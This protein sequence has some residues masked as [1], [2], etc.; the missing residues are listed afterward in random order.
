MRE[1][2][3]IL[4]MLFTLSAMVLASGC[5]RQAVVESILE[6][7]LEK[8]TGNSA[9]VDLEKGGMKLE[10]ADGV[11]LET[12]ESVKLP[13]DFPQ[14][15]Y[16]IDGKIVAV[17]KN[18]YGA[19]YNLSVQ[20]DKSVEEAK[21]IYEEKLKADGWTMGFSAVAGEVVMF[22]GQKDKRAVSISLMPDKETR[23]TSVVITLSEQTE[24]GE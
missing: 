7:Q 6:N 18:V 23:K 2:R 12:G 17:L 1:Y 3:T 24:G 10:T 5:G 4:V 13:D 16:V 22:S 14:D 21:L 15:V 8:A 20:S 19:G 9:E 11:S